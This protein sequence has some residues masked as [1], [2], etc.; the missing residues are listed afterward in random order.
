MKTFFG[1]AKKAFSIK[2]YIKPRHTQQYFDNQVINRHNDKVLFIKLKTI[3][4][5]TPHN[6][7][8]NKKQF[9]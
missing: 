4:I 3:I 9:F 1:F 8:K 5:S 6:L 7:N 2:R